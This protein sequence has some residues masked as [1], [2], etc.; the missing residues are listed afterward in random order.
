MEIRDGEWLLINHD[1]KTGRS[2]WKCYDG[3]KIH[4]RTDY[5]VNNIISE[6]AEILNNSCGQK[7]G[8]GKRVASIPLNV[9][10]DKIATAH[11]EGDEKYINKWLNDGDNRAFRTFEGNL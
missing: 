10:Y 8:D 2:V 9:F 3:N 7:F 11:N 1:V 6:N 5:P 4:F